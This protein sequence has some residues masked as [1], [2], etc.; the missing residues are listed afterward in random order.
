MRPP[1]RATIRVA[2]EG[3]AAAAA[4]DS[5]QKWLV[6]DGKMELNNGNSIGK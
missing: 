3:A 4:A 1:G 6:W 5:R 2:S